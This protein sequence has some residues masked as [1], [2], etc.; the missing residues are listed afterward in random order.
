MGDAQMIW[1][2]AAV[3][4]L[5]TIPGM[6]IAEPDRDCRIRLEFSSDNTGAVANYILTL[7]IKNALGRAVRG[8]SVKYFDG[9]A[10]QLGNTEMVCP[11]SIGEG[12]VPGSHGECWTQLQKVDGNLL[13]KFGTEMWTAIV[14]TQLIQLESIRKCKVLGFA[15]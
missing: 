5:L 15:Y 13:D 9:T 6:A 4:T 8:V 14:N 10:A 7:Q 12:I 1:R 3:V 11:G 2:A